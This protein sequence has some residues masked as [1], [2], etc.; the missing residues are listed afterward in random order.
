MDGKTRIRGL[1]ANPVGH[2]ASPMVHNF[3]AQRAGMSLAYIPFRVEEDRV[4]DTVKGA[5]T[6]DMLGV[7]VTVSHKQRIMELLSELSKD[8]KAA[9]AINTLVRTVAG[10][11]GYNTDGVGLKRALTQA[12][13]R[14]E[15]GHCLLTEAG[16]VARAV[17]YVLAKGRA[18][19]IHILN[20]NGTRARELV[21]YINTLT[22]SDL[23]EALPLKGYGGLPTRKD[24]YLAV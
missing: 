22:S 15:E 16:D 11:E 14:T 23:A 20:W 13:I 21:N 7:D 1:I 8:A 6:L 17:A 3:F 19:D 12:G 24:G 5:R 2:S 10:Y 9:G 18:A 4:E